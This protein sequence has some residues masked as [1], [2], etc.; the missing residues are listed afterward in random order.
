[1]PSP[2][3]AGIPPAPPAPPAPPPA[4]P[5]PPELLLDAVEPPSPPVEEDADEAGSDI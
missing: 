3:F 2:H 4:P 5:K 1:M